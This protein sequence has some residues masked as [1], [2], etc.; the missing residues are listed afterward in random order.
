MAEAARHRPEIEVDLGARSVHAKCGCGWGERRD[1]CS[2]TYTINDMVAEVVAAMLAH[3]EASAGVRVD[4]CGCSSPCCWPGELR[5]L[6]IEP[7]RVCRALYPGGGS[8]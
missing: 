4:W 5:S 7:G 1:S 8:A 3:V 6:S 2:W